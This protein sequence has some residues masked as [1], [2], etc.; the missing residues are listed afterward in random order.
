M[1]NQHSNADLMVSGF[2]FY[3][4]KGNNTCFIAPYLEILLESFPINCVYIMIVNFLRKKNIFLV[5]KI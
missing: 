2:L 1:I 4:V 5:C 3:I